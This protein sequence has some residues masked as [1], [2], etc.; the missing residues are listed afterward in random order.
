MR[1]HL[2]SISLALS[3]CAGG[4]TPPVD[5]AADHG[6]DPAKAAEA[7]AFVKKTEAELAE[8]WKTSQT[9]HWAHETNI[10][11]ETEA[12]AAKTDEEI[13]AYLSKAIPDAAA[14]DG[15][16]ADPDTERMLHLIKLGNTLPAP[17][18]PAKRA[19]LATI[20]TR[21]P[22]LYGKGQWCRAEG[23]CLDIGGIEDVLAKSRNP[24]ELRAAWEG[25]TAISVPM[26]ADYQ[27]FVELG[28]EG[29]REIGFTDMGHLWKSGYDM[30]PAELEAEVDRLWKQVSPLYEALQCHVRAELSEKYGKELVPEHGLIPTQLTGNLWAQDWQ[31]LYADLEPYPGQ[32]SIDVSK[33]LV[34]KKTDATAML[35]IGEGF[36]TSLGLEALPAT[37]WERSM[38]VKPTDRQ[39]VCHASA[40]DLDLERDL[41]V[42]MCIKPTLDDL[43]TIHHELGHLYYDDAYKVQP[44]LY[45]GGAHDGFHEAIGDA[46]ALSITP[47]YLK[48]IGLLTEAG[49]SEESVINVQMQTA[50]GKIAFLPFGLVVDRWRWEV[51]DGRIAPDQYNAGWWRLKAELQGVAPPAERGEEWF[52][53]GAKYHVPG[54]TPYLR[55]FLAHILQFQF[56]KSMCE[57]AGFKGPLHQC[58]VYGSKE[59][60]ARLQKMLELGQ[61]EPWPDALEAMTGTRTMDASALVTYFDPLMTWL[62]EQNKDRQ[63]GWDLPA[64][65]ATTAPP[66]QNPAGG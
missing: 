20:S 37:F 34:E 23:D 65:T 8:L 12:A 51:F 3:S 35:K 38:I 31:N 41:R 66:A 5:H 17:S 48:Q 16:E 46:I 63:C 45:R 44:V 36:Y 6:A 60:G 32:P 62:K 59:A 25:W 21:M 56:H 42:K 2:L 43:I 58:S 54:N 50:L 27:K 33:T 9:A 53:A 24:Q 13:M 19:E 28:N 64:A 22:S 18:D 15:V 52:D 4:K 49:A 55:Y 30:A 14:F 39:V 11:P 1:H 61:S 10:T 26:R 7:T 57:A 47:S 40:W 29:A